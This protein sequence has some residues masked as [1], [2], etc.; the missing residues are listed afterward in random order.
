MPNYY[1]ATIT[2]PRGS[3]DNMIDDALAG[4][5]YNQGS[6]H[7]SGGCASALDPEP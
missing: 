1:F 7:S 2:C 4:G 6:A 3:L 5:S